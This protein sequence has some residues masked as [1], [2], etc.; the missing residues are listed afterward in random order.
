MHCVMHYDILF[1]KLDVS[2]QII[3]AVLFL[4]I[5][6][7]SFFFSPF[8]FPGTWV[9]GSPHSISHRTELNW[10]INH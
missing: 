2:P 6:L 9:H 1:R 3:A 7:H 4:D 10:L 8:P 5:S